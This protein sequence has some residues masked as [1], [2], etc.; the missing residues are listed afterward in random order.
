M[1]TIRTRAYTEDRAGQ[2][3]QRTAAGRV[4]ESVT[5]GSA[6]VT[7][8]NFLVFGRADAIDW[9][10]KTIR[11]ERSSL[12]SSLS[13]AEGKNKNAEDGSEVHL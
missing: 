9:A 2:A 13:K 8:N 1:T 5:F 10:R 4:G 6:N 11:T 3:F 12:R 7:K